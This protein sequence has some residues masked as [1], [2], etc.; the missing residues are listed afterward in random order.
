LHLTGLPHPASGSEPQLILP[1]GWQQVGAYAGRFELRQSGAVEI[2]VPAGMAGAPA[3]VER[4]NQLYAAAV[5]MLGDQPL[6]KTVVLVDGAPTSLAGS[7][8]DLWM[9]A[10]AD[11]A[12]WWATGAAGVYA[13]KLLDQTKLWTDQEKEKWTERQFKEKGFAL[14]TWL[15]ATLRLSTG[16]KQALDPVFRAALGAR[17]NADVLKAVRYWKSYLKLD[18]GSSWSAI[19]RREL[20]KLRRETVVPGREN[21]T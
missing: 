9:P 3:A 15:D 8:V 10:Y 19:A 20:D 2:A 4:V 17:T 21:G 18:G 12:H 6:S 7:V 13:E 11:D 14:V 5:A 1:D 16:S